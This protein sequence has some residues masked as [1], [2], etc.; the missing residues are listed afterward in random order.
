MKHDF[1]I[2]HLSLQCFSTLFFFSTS[3]SYFN[4][5]CLL[6]RLLEAQSNFNI[7]PCVTAISYIV[8]SKLPQ[9][10]LWQLICWLGLTFVSKDMS[11]WSRLHCRDS[12]YDGII[13]ST[14]CCLWGEW[15]G[16]AQRWQENTHTVF[17]RITAPWMR[18][19]WTLVVHY[20]KQSSLG[21]STS[22]TSFLPIQRL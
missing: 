21:K 12:V 10:A 4:F 1:W 14:S 11:L 9:S 16:N 6:L 20:G 5:L 2:T 15:D 7:T 8:Q 13:F 18:W 19:S 3:V 22:S 17:Y